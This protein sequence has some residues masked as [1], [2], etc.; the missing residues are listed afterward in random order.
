MYV[1]KHG[2]VNIIRECPGGAPTLLATLTSGDFFGE[3][4]LIDDGPRSASAIAYGATEAIGFFKPDFTT[5]IQAR[6]AIGLKISIRL[7]KTLS[8]RL[9]RTN[10]ELQQLHLQRRQE[11]RILEQA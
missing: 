8:A 3:I 9:R 10:E 6:P 2:G 7:G 4:G 11:S 5:L 1:I